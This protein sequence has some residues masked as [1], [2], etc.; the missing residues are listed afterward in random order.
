MQQVGQLGNRKK[1]I[2]ELDVVRDSEV[3]GATLEKSRY[4]SPEPRYLGVPPAM[5][6]STSG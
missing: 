6:Y 5:R 2:V 3:D 1:A 4:C